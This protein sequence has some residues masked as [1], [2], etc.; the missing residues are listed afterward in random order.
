MARSD[1]LEAMGTLRH[2][3]TKRSSCMWVKQYHKPSWV[4]LFLVMFTHINIP[5]QHFY[6]WYKPFSNGWFMALSHPHYIVIKSNHFSKKWDVRS[7]LFVTMN[8]YLG[9]GKCQP[10]WDF[11]HHQH[12]YLVEMISSIVSWLMFIWDINTKIPGWWFATFF[13]FH[14]LGIVTPIDFHIFQRGWIKPPT[15]Y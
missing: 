14:I 2:W 6:R 13:I 7:H 1:F 5:N 3:R 4:S 8:Q 9:V 15:R 11:E 10:F 12:M